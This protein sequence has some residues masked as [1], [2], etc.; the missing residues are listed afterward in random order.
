MCRIV[1]TALPGDSR[2]PGQARAW[3]DRWL[4]T[5]GIDDEGV[6]TLLVS[7]LV[8]NAV[9]HTRAAPTLALAVAGGMIE[10]GVTDGGS[11]RGPIPVQRE[12]V[13]PGSVRVLSE[14]G[15]GL[16]IVEALSDDWGVT[17]N[18][19]GKQVW[20]R[21]AVA[22]SWQYGPG[23]RCDTHDP[24]GHDL[25]SGHRVLDIPGPWDPPAA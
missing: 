25:P 2:S 7:E 22:P 5:W 8:T 12:V 10:A 23:C 4:D 15:R 11:L 3:V 14:T 20:F 1:S 6:T 9:K 19:T 17:P 18:G 13:A 21:R 24:T 16:M